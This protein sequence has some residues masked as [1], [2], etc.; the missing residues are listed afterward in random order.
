[1]NAPALAPVAPH[2]VPRDAAPGTRWFRV[3]RG[4]HFAGRD[5][6]G[7]DL[8]GCSGKVGLGDVL[9]LV[10]AGPGGPKFATSRRDGFRGELGEP[11]DPRRWQPAGRIV[12]VV[13]ATCPVPESPARVIPFRRRPAQL[14]LFERPAR[15]CA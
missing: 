7:G 2:E 13:A 4:G 14:S 11:C 3:A 10:S 1:M 5:W 15:A 8:V 12:R 6:R 9:V